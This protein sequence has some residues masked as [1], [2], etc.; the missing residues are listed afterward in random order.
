M[1]VEE[2]APRKT[3]GG[4]YLPRSTNNI[5]PFRTTLTDAIA[6]YMNGTVP[7]NSPVLMN[8]A[9]N[10]VAWMKPG[11]M[12]QYWAARLKECPN[13]VMANLFPLVAIF[14]SSSAEAERTFS[15]AGFI[16]DS[17]RTRMRPELVRVLTVGR[18]VLHNVHKV[19]GKNAVCTFIHK[20]TSPTGSTIYETTGDLYDLF[21][22]D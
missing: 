22:N 5:I 6:A 11:V 13:D 15:S 17:L 7:V 19:S 21:L 16:V 2:A 14:R 1:P 3:F 12:E 4:H 18:S 9:V 10:P 20:T 8:D